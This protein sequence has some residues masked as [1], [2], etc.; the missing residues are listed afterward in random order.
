MAAA[1]IP[2]S[3][4]RCTRRSK[5]VL[6]VVDGSRVMG[7]PIVYG[8]GVFAGLSVVVAARRWARLW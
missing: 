8:L 5:T 2:R 3:I 1:S 7:I 6:A 4:P